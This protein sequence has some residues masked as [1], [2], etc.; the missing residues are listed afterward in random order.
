M[1]AEQGLEFDTQDASFCR[2]KRKRS[3]NGTNKKQEAKAARNAERIASGGC[4]R[5]K[6]PDGLTKQQREFLRCYVIAPT[7]NRAIALA[8]KNGVRIPRSNPGSWVKGNEVFARKFKRAKRQALHYLEVEA[9]RRAVE[10]V[11]R[12][13]HFKGLPVLNE[14]GEPYHE[15]EY[16]DQLLMFLMKNQMPKKYGDKSKL[17]LAGSVSLSNI[18]DAELEE[19]ERQLGIIPQ[20]FVLP[21]AAQQTN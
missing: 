18:S 2:P 20:R 7:I 9:R 12:L 8:A 13:K 19:R 15:F 5:S 3:P 17:E 11:S 6:G 4:D 1:N 16:S 14:E 21:T 10:G